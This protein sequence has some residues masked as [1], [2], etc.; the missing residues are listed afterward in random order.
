M[1][2]TTLDALYDAYAKHTTIHGEVIPIEDRLRITAHGR[3]VRKRRL[4]YVMRAVLLL[5]R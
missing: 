1:S 3:F 5:L 2:L 4:S